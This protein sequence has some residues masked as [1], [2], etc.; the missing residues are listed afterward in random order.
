M[1]KECAGWEGSAGRAVP[2]R[3]GRAWR[4][5]RQAGTFPLPTAPCAPQLAPLPKVKAKQLGDSSVVRSRARNQGADHR[6]FTQASLRGARSRRRHLISRDSGSFE[7]IRC[8]FLR[9]DRLRRHRRD[10]TG[11]PFRPTREA[12]RSRILLRPNQLFDP[13]SWSRQS[14]LP[15]LAWVRPGLP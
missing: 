2:G 6:S 5:R 9:V 10:A 13:K 3:L 12:H 11:C 4:S 14:P 1:G 7:E 8:R 15:P